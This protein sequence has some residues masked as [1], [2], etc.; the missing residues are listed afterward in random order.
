MTTTLKSF[1]SSVLAKLPHSTLNAA[2]RKLSGYPKVRAAIT[3]IFVDKYAL[4]LPVRPRPISMA[5]E[6]PTWPSLVD[7]RYSGRHL[8]ACDA[9]SAP[10]EIPMDLHLN[11]FRRETFKPSADTSI[12]FAMFAQW[13]TDGFLRTKWE[14]P[15]PDQGFRFNES[16]HEIDL[17]Q[18][19]G[20]TEAQTDMLR[21]KDA[22]NPG[23]LKFQMI[24]DEMW[25]SA[26]MA[27]DEN[28][29]WQLL[30]EFETRYPTA[31]D[32]GSPGLYTPANFQR[33]FANVPPEE[34]GL[35]MAVGLEHGNSTMGHVVMNVLFLREH[36][37]VADH[38]AATQPSWDDERVFQTA[39]NVVVAELLHIVIS[40]YIPHIAPFEFQLEVTPGM[41]E[42]KSWY[43]TNW[44]PVEFALLYRWHDLIPDKMT[45]N[46]SDLTAAEMRWC[47]GWLRGH[48]LCAVISAASQQFS[49][50]IGLHNTHESLIRVKEASLAMAK[51]CRLQGY[52]AYRELCG[53][54]PYKTFLELTRDPET[55]R[56][57]EDLYGSID[58]LDWLTGIFAEGY[59]ESDMM[60][61]LLV[62]M[63]ANDAF[64]QALTNPL[65]SRALYNEGTFSPIGMQIVNSTRRLSQLIARNT[66]LP[67]HD[68]DSFLVHPANPANVTAPVPARAGA[69]GEG[70]PAA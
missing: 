49:G 43:R 69:A 35:A 24:N 22:S 38:I 39:R 10:A 6:Y 3:E 33:V 15:G 17:N 21:A 54:M 51:G 64:T 5:A 45:V 31:T 9:K 59:G 65:I 60:G 14:P 16:N 12:L 40:D 36:N 30:P 67:E 19:Y 46:G 7:R 62:T 42:R 37:R 28:G 26:L 52:N 11:L 55:A 68:N 70:V 56:E 34:L 41:A 63:V 58:R 47:I 18:I 50:K 23:R 44:I 57:L 4:S 25:P 32:P 29:A 48:G 61:D 66:G 53:M 1:A 20:M 2:A 27:Q 8:A 13:F